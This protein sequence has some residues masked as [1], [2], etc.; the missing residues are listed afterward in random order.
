VDY[1]F[2]HNKASANHVLF[3]SIAAFVLGIYSFTLPK[4]P[5]QKLIS[6]DATIVD[7]KIRIECF[8][9]VWNL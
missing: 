1:E 3:I 5:P 9:T 2:T 4:C 6:D 8:Q 7:R